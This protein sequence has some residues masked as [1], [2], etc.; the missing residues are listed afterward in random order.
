MNF[1][2]YFILPMVLV[3]MCKKPHSKIV[4]GSLA[5]LGRLSTCKVT[6]I[7]PLRKFEN[8][9][10]FFLRVYFSKDGFIPHLGNAPG[11]NTQQT[12]FQNFSPFSHF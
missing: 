6:K 3:T 7:Y 2:V 12:P 10:Y 4:H 11:D 8:C 9:V 5:I 1:V